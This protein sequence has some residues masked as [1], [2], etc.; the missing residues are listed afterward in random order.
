[1]RPYVLGL[2]RYANVAPLH[3]FL[4]LEG[5]RVLHAVPAELNRLLLSGE[6]GLSLVSSYF[7]LN[8]FTHPWDASRTRESGRNR[9]ALGH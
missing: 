3:H 8:G 4:R 2:P 1:M 5:F 6:V 9:F 7:Y